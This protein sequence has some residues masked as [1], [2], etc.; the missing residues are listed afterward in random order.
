MSNWKLMPRYDAILFDFDGV[1]ADSEPVHYACWRAALADLDLDLDWDRFAGQCVGLSERATAQFLLKHAR[2]PA[3]FE[4]V[5]KRYPAKQALLRER[6]HANPP[7]LPETVDLI[8]ELEAYKLGVVT[9]SGHAGIDP[10]LESSGLR[11]C[12]S[13]VICEEDVER[14][15]PAPDPY[16]KA[17]GIIGA[18][19]PLVV[20]DSPVGLESGRAAGFDV[21][22]VPRAEQMPDLLRE[23][24]KL[25]GSRQA[26]PLRPC[27]KRRR[28]TGGPL[29]RPRSKPGAGPC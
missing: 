8:R 6:M 17:A 23:K 3:T 1:L 24:L 10:V 16:L 13:V 9:S 19:R 18:R 27:R 20:E 11:P 12:L 26:A 15:K 28:V 4:E 29:E 14:H 7:V 2:K 5:W 22:L 25:N 21:L